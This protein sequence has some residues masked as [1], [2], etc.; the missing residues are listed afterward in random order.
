M[1]GGRSAM[2]SFQPGSVLLSGD[3]REQTDQ[4][5]A[6]QEAGDDEVAANFNQIFSY[7]DQDGPALQEEEEQDDEQDED[8]QAGGL[9]QLPTY[10]L[11]RPDKQDDQPI[12]EE[13]ERKEH[14]QQ[15]EEEEQEEQPQASPSS[16]ASA[17][18]EAAKRAARRFDLQLGQIADAGIRAVFDPTRTDA[19][20]S[21]H[22]LMEWSDERLAA[23]VTAMRPEHMAVMIRKR[24]MTNETQQAKRLS[25]HHLSYSTEGKQV[26]KDC[27]G[28]IEPGEMVGI[29]GGPDSGV[30]SLLGLLAGTIASASTTKEVKKHAAGD[31]AAANEFEDSKLEDSRFEDSRFEDSRLEDSRLGSMDDGYAPASASAP[32]V[33][34]H[35]SH[36]TRVGGYIL[37]D[38]L[39][40][41]KE[42]QQQVG[43]APK[44]DNH[45]PFLTGTHNTHTNTHTEQASNDRQSRRRRPLT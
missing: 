13:E 44:N 36:A 22:A 32:H 9:Q 31:A 20:S 10:G 5:Q 43:F 27:S 45:L 3:R 21:L 6:R 8:S 25:F 2:S 38:G 37:Y 35:I 28:F 7:K 29:C 18:S 15:Q 34:G 33:E 41:K 19:A 17:A 12:T 14:T 4:E 30:S 40:R 42:F 1:L 26:L 11:I 39:K 23:L 24:V 16:S